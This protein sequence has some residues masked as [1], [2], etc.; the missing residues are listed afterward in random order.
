MDFLWIPMDS[1]GFLWILMDP[2]GQY[3]HFPHLGREPF[4]QI[5]FKNSF[6]QGGSSPLISAEL[7]CEVR[8]RFSQLQANDW[9]IYGS[10]VSEVLQK[11]ICFG[12]QW[13]LH[14]YFLFSEVLQRSGT[15]SF[16]IQANP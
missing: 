9:R 16:R 13:I 11:W 8:S 4:I 3:H 14:V 12:F 7:V 5:L 10:G 1:F 2:G 15:I 6:I